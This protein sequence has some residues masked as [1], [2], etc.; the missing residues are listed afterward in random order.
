MHRQRDA[1][2]WIRA[3]IGFAVFVALAAVGTAAFAFAV[4]AA[5][6]AGSTTTTAERSG[7]TS[8]AA[9]AVEALLH[10]PADRAQSAIP[11]DF[12]AETGYRPLVDGGM[13]INPS[14]GCSSPV[15]LPHRFDPACKAH[16][17]GYDLLR[18]A[19]EHGRPLGP[20]A[21][22][23][24]DAQFADRLRTT[25]G[26]E[27]PLCLTAADTAIT[28][29]QTNSWRQGYAIPLAEDE[30][31][32][33]LGGI[34]SATAVATVGYAVVRRRRSATSG[35]AGDIEAATP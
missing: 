1:T 7:S 33:V 14:G 32:Y 19:Q 26:G 10:D 2:Q 29:V 35:R 6:S 11:S 16:D 15:P 25:C 3:A 8:A 28:A 21:R 20:W 9:M 22:Q 31:V 13:L 5:A 4:P 23:E 17:V 30:A 34:A 27:N 24:L 12:A 18:Y